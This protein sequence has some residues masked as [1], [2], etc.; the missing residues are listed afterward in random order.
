MASAAPSDHTDSEYVIGLVL[1]YPQL[2]CIERQTYIHTV[3]A[4]YYIDYYIDI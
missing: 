2:E 1:K 3:F 4:L